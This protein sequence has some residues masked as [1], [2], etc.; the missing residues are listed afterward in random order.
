MNIAKTMIN[1][2]AFVF[3]MCDLFAQAPGGTIKGA[4]ITSD[5]K[6]AASV[7]IHLAGTKKFTVTNDDGTFN[8]NNLSP[9]NYLLE[10]SLVGYDTLR[11]EVQVQAGS[12]TSVDLQLNLSG[13]QLQEVVINADRNRRTSKESDYIA[14]MPLKNLE[15]PQVYNVVG[16]ELMKEQMMTDIREPFRAAAGVVPSQYVTGMFNVTLRGFTTWDYARNGLATSVERSGTELANLE[17]VEL[18]KGPSGTLFGSSVSS[19]GGVMNLVTKKPYSE[20]GGSVDY[21][22]GS[23]DLSRAAIDVNAPLNRE[24]TLLLRV[25]AV[26]HRQNSSNE[27]GKNRRY[28]VA[29]SLSYQVNDRL[30]LLFDYEYFKSNSTQPIYT[31]FGDAS[32]F[33]SMKEIPLDF[34][35]SFFENDLLSSIESSR[36]Y[37]HAQY[38]L[39]SNWTS[40][41]DISNVNESVGSSYQPY[42]R[43]LDNST[44]TPSVRLFGP[45]ERTSGNIQQNFNASFSTGSIRHKLLIGA[46]F[47]YITETV[48]YR[49]SPNIDTID[50]HAA[51]EKVNKDRVDQ[52]IAA[53]SKPIFSG[54]KQN[55]LGMY[56]SDVIN[57]TDRLSTMLSL[58]WDR[59]EDPS[60]EGFI[61]GSLSPKLGLVYKLVKN[62]V[63]LFAN[64]MN[65]FQN[66]GPI[67]QPD[68]IIFKP[69]PVFANQWEGGLK[70][71]LLNNKLST[72]ISYYHIG[73]DNAIRTDDNLVSFQDG[74]QLSKGVELELIANPVAGLNIITGYAYNENKIIKA[75]DYERKLVTGAPRHVINYWISYRLPLEHIKGIGLGFGGNYVSD[76]YYNASNTL[77]IPANHLLNATVFYD[78]DKWRIGVKLNNINNVQYWDLMGFQQVT[79]NFV[80]GFTFKF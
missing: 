3:I 38:R 63:S 18:I 71:E 45:R 22:L 39:G 49:V 75:Q 5:N 7:T 2:L 11:Q 73:I 13:K 27:Y 21:S 51:F 65:G 72:T 17:R 12:I 37:L 74:K 69:K 25:N 1:T 57:W 46:S 10:V 53:S 55:A 20:F 78:K 58:R 52:V 6:P 62:R 19:Y 60:D 47:E 41:T 28:S 59:F 31:L 26:Q 50:V 56:A 61:Q 23:F 29:P 48:T 30:S 35:K 80:A 77:V 64:Y 67:T 14:R 15:N 8:L 68:G 16:K 66:Q 70:A 76:A 79:R 40:N 42:I 34:S 44:A 24:K 9:K 4:V 32:P 43:W 54:Y 33:A 36:Y